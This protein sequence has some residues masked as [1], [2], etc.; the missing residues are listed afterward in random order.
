MT[1]A[2]LSSPELRETSCVAYQSLIITILLNWLNIQSL[3]CYFNFDRHPLHSRC[4]NRQG[5]RW[6][7]KDV[8]NFISICCQL[9]PKYFTTSAIFSQCSSTHQ[10][11]ISFP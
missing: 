11:R 3:S 7:T 6:Y 5:H 9:H 4:P 8:N 1:A 2:D 10:K